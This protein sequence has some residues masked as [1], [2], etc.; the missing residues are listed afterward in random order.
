[1]YLMVRFALTQEF[2]EENFDWTNNASWFSVKLLIS[3]VG[4]DYT[5]SMKTS[6][7][8][9]AV[10]AILLHLGL[11]LTHLAHLG[12]NMGAK[13]LE[14]L[15]IESEEIRRLG[16]WNPSMQAA[17]Y[18][19]K[20]PMK[21]IRRLGGFATGNG[22]HFNKR[23]VVIPCQE[24]QEQTPIGRWV[25][26]GLAQVLAANAQ[27]AKCYTAQHFLEFMVELNII[28][29]QDMAVMCNEH[30]DRLEGHPIITHVPCLA[31]TAFAV[32]L[33]PVARNTWSFLI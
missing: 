6:T 23:T 24:L 29:L 12:R 32:S 28:F 19:T 26:H 8:A 20:L 18:S 5:K 27:N 14:M 30:P 13:I 31:S 33:L 7:Y 11:A 4:T 1:M 21:A 22:I 25:F 16:N 9:K 2:S 15:E 10:K 17:R 3:G